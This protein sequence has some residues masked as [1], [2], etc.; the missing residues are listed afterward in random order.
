MIENLRKNLGPIV[1]GVVLSFVLLGFVLQ[2]RNSH[3][4]LLGREQAVM[5][6][7]GRNYDGMEFHKL[8]RSSV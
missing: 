2:D 6:V 1:I 5:R 3:M 4:S 7:D 8:G